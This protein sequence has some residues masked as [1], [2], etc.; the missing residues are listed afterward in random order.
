MDLRIAHGLQDEVTSERPQYLGAAC[1][2]SFFG[3]LEKGGWE[4]DKQASSRKFLDFMSLSSA[5]RK[6]DRLLHRMLP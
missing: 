4:S 5:N 2:T 1:A 6:L 3:V